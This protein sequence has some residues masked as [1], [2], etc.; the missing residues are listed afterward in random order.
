MALVALAIVGIIA[1][2]ALSIDIGTLYQASAEAQRAA[3][4]G[5]LAAARLI[6]MSGLT[7]DPTNIATWAKTCGAGGPAGLAAVAAAQQNAVG[8]R[9]VPTP[10][11]S[12]TYTA[13][14]AAVNTGLPDCSGAGSEFPINPVVTVIVQQTKLPT[15]FAHVFGIFNKNWNAV[16]ASATATAE[17]FNSS[18]ADTYAVQPRCVKPWMVPNE[19]P[20]NPAGCTGACNPFVITSNNGSIQNPGILTNGSG[21]IGESFW[22]VPDCSAGGAACTLLGAPGTQ[23]QANPGPPPSSLQYVPG[24]V[25][26]LGIATAIPSSKTGACSAISGSAYA[27]AIAGC[28]QSTQYECG[29]T[30]FNKVDL[31]ENPIST[32]DTTNGAQCLIHQ[33]VNSPSD[34]LTPASVS[35]Q[36]TLDPFATIEVPPPTYPFQIEAGTDNPLTGA[37]LNSGSVITSST[38]I[39]TVPIY[40]PT[41]TVIAGTGTTSVTIVGFLQVFINFVDSTGKVY[42]TVMNVTGCG[43]APSTVLHGTSPVP[44]RLITAP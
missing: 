10:S 37:G 16:T 28:D 41:G 17:A 24:Q 23:P 44:V 26:P 14:S 35:G 2:A 20:L 33:G 7:G 9:S 42:V 34:A 6:S 40:N 22:L 15:F 30:G 4:A 5:A 1:M 38:S 12:V 43:N 32:N 36:D 21:V 39:A 27:E 13:G 25:P 3:D 31:T 8:G 29:E 18:N 19:D 11:I